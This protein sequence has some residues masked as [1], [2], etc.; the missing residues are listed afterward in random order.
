VAVALFGVDLGLKIIFVDY[1]ETRDRD[2]VG[3]ERLLGLI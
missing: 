2:I 3:G 1:E